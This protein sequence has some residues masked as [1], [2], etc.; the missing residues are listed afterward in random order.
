VPELVGDPV[1]D[2][3]EAEMIDDDVRQSASLGHSAEEDAVHV[4]DDGT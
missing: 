4:V 3:Q 2:D 1:L